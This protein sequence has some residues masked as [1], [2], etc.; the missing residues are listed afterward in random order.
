MI[1]RTIDDLDNFT[2]SYQA[3]HHGSATSG[4]TL[5][6]ELANAES[7]PGGPWGSGPVKTAVSIGG[8]YLHTARDHLSSLSKLIDPPTTALGWALP[9]RAV[10]EGAARAWW[11]L[12]P[13]IGVRRRVARSMTERLD[14]LNSIIA[15]QRA[16]DGEPQAEQIDRREALL[17]EADGLGLEQ[18][19]SPKKRLPDGFG[20]E[21]RPGLVEMLRKFSSAHEAPAGEGIARFLSAFV[22]SSTH[23][24]LQVWTA[25]AGVDDVHPFDDDDPDMKIAGPQLPFNLVGSAAFA[26]LRGYFDAAESEADLYGWDRDVLSSW[27]LHS[28]KK[29]ANA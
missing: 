7:G 29:V 8:L 21:R 24:T 20:S 14:T 16:F 25:E 22:H 28:L 6:I 26:A 2:A 13:T 10:L 18:I 17:A 3:M 11:L 19:E 27:R 15:M 5:A 23:G 4:S 1:V 9:S 12:D